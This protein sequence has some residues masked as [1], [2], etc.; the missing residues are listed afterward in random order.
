MNKWPLLIRPLLIFL[1]LSVPAL[2]MAEE[3]PVLEMHI[4]LNPDTGELGG[5]LRL[6][7]PPPVSRFSLLSGL[8]LKHAHDEQQRPVS[9][10]RQGDSYDLVLD[11]SVSQLHLQWEGQLSPGHGRIRLHPEGSLLSGNGGWYPHPES[12]EDFTAEIVVHTPVGQRAVATGSRHYPMSSSTS[13][14]ESFLGM[15]ATE[16]EAAHFFHPRIDGI[17][18]ATGPWLPRSRFV[19]DIELMTLFPAALDEALAERYLDVL[20]DYLPAFEERAGPYPYQSFTVA[21]SPLPVGLA[22]PGWTLLGESVLPL[23]FIPRTSLAHEF[24]HSWWGTGVRIDFASGNWAEGLTTYMADYF[25]DEQRGEARSTRERWLLD[26]AWLPVV[27]DHPL[28]SFRSGNQGTTRIIGYNRAAGVFH[29]LRER[30]GEEA[31][32]AGTR[33]LNERFRYQVASWDDLQ[34]L[35]AETSGQTLDAFFSHWLER[36]GLPRL[37]W[38]AL[39]QEITTD[40]SWL[41]G[42]L[43]QVGNDPPWPLRV[44]IVLETDQEKTTHWLP[45]DS[46]SHTIRIPFSGTLLSVEVDPEF[47][48]LRHWPN[49]PPIVRTVTLDPDTRSLL[50][51]EGLEP[52]LNALLPNQRITPLEDPDSHDPQR[53]LLI[54]GSTQDVATLIGNMGLKT[55]LLSLHTEGHARFWTL[56]D[57]RTLVISADTAQGLAAIVRS[58][59]HHGHRSYAVQ[60]ENGRILSSGVWHSSAATLRW[61]PDSPPE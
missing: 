29:M 57:T 21:A 54:M 51:Q 49:P 6:T 20:A 43:S 4:A 17:T 35:F 56:P 2:L 33:L 12:L 26:L 27:A 41:I 14:P 60:D 11:A 15:L 59:R 40:G 9:W 1:Y 45:L 61:Q 24:K 48:T 3:L 30:I 19:G 38:T 55:P 31:F 58:L 28:R 52:F 46:G 50:T 16:G 18:L 44:P 34:R 36:P 5:E 47:E 23:P 22:F 53:P 37:E 10:T 39:D 13:N 32:F 8:E 42:E 7:P 25:M